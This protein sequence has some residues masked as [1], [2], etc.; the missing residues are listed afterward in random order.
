LQEMKLAKFSCTLD[1]YISE[2]IYRNRA[3]TSV[4]S[5]LMR[6]WIRESFP[7][8]LITLVIHV[9]KAIV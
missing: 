7:I 2:R 3:E 8:M 5:E 1:L 9:S 4:F 6:Y